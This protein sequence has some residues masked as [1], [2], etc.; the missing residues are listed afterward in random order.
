MPRVIMAV[1]TGFAFMGQPHY[2]EQSLDMID[3]KAKGV[4]DDDD[5]EA[6][7]MGKTIQKS[8]PVASTQEDED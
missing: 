6:L 8:I 5:I 2:V 7:L 4:I 3:L 1:R